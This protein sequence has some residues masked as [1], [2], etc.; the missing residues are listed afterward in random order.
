[1]Y[2]PLIG[3]SARSRPANSQ[4]SDDDLRASRCSAMRASSR[5]I[6]SRTASC[7]SSLSTLPEATPAA[8]C[9]V[10]EFAIGRI[11]AGLTFV[12]ETWRAVW[13]NRGK[14]LASHAY[15]EYGHVAQSFALPNFHATQ[16]DVLIRRARACVAS[17]PRFL[18]G[19]A[20]E[21]LVRQ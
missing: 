4:P 11:S 20:K 8:Y 1:M 5:A 18:G 13:S 17:A 9:A 12:N 6:M 10:T 7:A 21:G 14:R 16:H 15:T 19:S 3:G 2:R